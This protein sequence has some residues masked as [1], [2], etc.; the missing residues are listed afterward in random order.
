[1]TPESIKLLYLTAGAV[2]SL[3]VLVAWLRIH[4]F[5]ALLF[6]ALV[7]GLG[8]GLIDA[9]SKGGGVPISPAGVAM[10]F[11]DGM[12]K[13]LGGIAAVL[14]LGTM[15]GGLLAAS[16]GAE[17]LSQRLVGFFGAK[18]VNLVLMIVALAVGFTTWFAVGLIMLLPIL[19]T[20][21]KETK[22]PFL[23]LALPMLAVLSIMHGVMPPHPGPL[24]AL[25]ELG[26]SLGKVVLWGLVAAIP[27]AAVSGPFF[28]HWAVR[29]VAVTAPEPPAP[30]PSIFARERPTL[31][32]T[33]AALA[34]PVILILSH[35]ISELIFKE[36]L[37]SG[38]KPALYQLTEIIGNPILA[39]ALAVLFAAWAFRF[40]RN[41]ALKVV[42]KSLGPVGMTLLLVGGGGGF[43]NVLQASGAA[44]AIGAMAAKLDMPT[45]LFAWVCAAL[46]RIAT[47]S[48]TVAII[49][50]IGLVKPVLAAAAAA[51]PEW[52]A[53]PALATNPELL[54]V[55]IGCG[56]MVL[57]HVN[58]AGFWIVKESLGLTVPQTL[59]T[60][61]VTE[62]LIGITGLG[63]AWGLDLFF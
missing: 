62:T 30:D 42:E 10:A 11:Q 63:V 47:G 29:H 9:P 31:F 53:N 46:I 22:Q 54:V 34:L 43:N 32:R 39:L 36:D 27:I 26:A 57:S 17:V 8:A 48:A 51:H 49:A 18:R 1:M 2:V 28:A 12:G 37:A 3:I 35:T 60:W 21:T 13:S 5:L 50:A 33:V 40:T 41:D 7:V 16:G 44:E 24:Y 23:K 59:R 52:A 55:A 19:L 61:T 4:A 38:R 25:D 56:A 14:G 45:M 20:L 6:A 15:L 58:D